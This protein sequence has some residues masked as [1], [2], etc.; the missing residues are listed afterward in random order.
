MIY[1]L[2]IEDGKEKPV[3]NFLKQLDFISVKAVKKDKTAKKKT[4]TKPLQDPS[5]FDSYPNW[6]MDIETIR[7]KSTK[8]RLNGWLKRPA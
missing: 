4:E 1:E 8:K 3:I 7:K 2:I 5:Y 6:E